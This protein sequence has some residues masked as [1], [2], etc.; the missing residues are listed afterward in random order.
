MIV[1]NLIGWCKTMEH[2]FDFSSLLTLNLLF[3]GS[4]IFLLIRH[5][6]ILR[7]YRFLV[8][9][10]DRLHHEFFKESEKRAVAEEKNTRI[11]EIEKIVQ[12]KE[13]AIA[14]F[15]AENSDLKSR[16]TES[17][18]RQSQQ[19]LYEKEK[20]ELLSQ[21]QASLTESFKALSSDAL[22]R[23]TVSF[24]DL[25]TTKFDKL[26]E[27]AAGELRL[28]QHAIDELVKPIKL[29]LEK[30]DGKLSEIEKE[31]IH[32]YSGLTEQVKSLMAT[33]TYLHNET[34]NL[35]K[36][37]R[38]PNVRGRWGEIQLR[39]VVEMAGM[40][41]HCDFIQQKSVAV[42]DRRL[43]PDLVI[44]LPNNRQVIVDSK[45]PLQAYL[46]SLESKDEVARLS[47]LND[48][49][50][51][52]RLHITQLS[53]KNYWEQFQTAP[54]FVVLF[55]PGETFYSAALERDPELIEWGV[56]QK[57]IIATPTTLIALLRAVSYG[58]RQEMIAE[59]AQK[60]SELGKSLYD[61]LR[62]MADHFEDVRRG[63]DKAVESYNKAMGSFEG[64]VLIS[65][66]KFKE[67]GSGTEEEIPYIEAIDVKTRALKIEI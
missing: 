33:Q 17:E 48:H 58:W 41:E 62:V 36:A 21:T 64:R 19:A 55:L 63:L 39:R 8:E 66:R 51:Q 34:S 29:S 59:N 40:I 47:K 43:R 25:A 38:S 35:V 67:L 54:E 44:Q 45:V 9:E 6:R 42:E 46:D 2:F 4:F 52:L 30:V 31:R 18:T 11:P 37:L 28:R 50:R 27:Q 60:I 1:F 53:A 22:H 16:L 20:I 10:K 32:A 24:L 65:A 61:R 12:A 56:D 3:L 13:E 57:V 14:S 23:N 7:R 15:L 5:S 49:A 26:Q